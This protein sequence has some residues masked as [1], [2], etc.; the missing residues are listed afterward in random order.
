MALVRVVGRTYA[1]LVLAILAVACRERSAQTTTPSITPQPA[2]LPTT[3]QP[4]QPTPQPVLLGTPEEAKASGRRL[5]EDEL[6]DA[7]LDSEFQISSSEG[8]RKR[9]ASVGDVRESR[10]IDEAIEVRA[11]ASDAHFLVIHVRDGRGGWKFS[12]AQ[13]VRGT[14]AAA[15]ATVTYERVEARLR[16]RL[17]K[18]TWVQAAGAPPP[19]K[20][21]KFGD[22]GLEVSLLQREDQSGDFTVEVTL[23]EP[24]GEGE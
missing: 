11:D 7:L 14:S 1:A 17:G 13:A 23:A 20:G 12:H 9:L 10:P 8:A 3:A 24:Q 15:A 21:W 19:V 2:E 16:K 5:S 22:R 6:V 4:T 18:P